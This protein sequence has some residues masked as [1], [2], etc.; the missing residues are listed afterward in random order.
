MMQDEEDDDDRSQ[1]DGYEFQDQ[2]QDQDQDENEDY[3]QGAMNIDDVNAIQDRGDSESE[4]ELTDQE[5]LVM[6]SM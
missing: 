3:H 1:T 5:Q 6:T 4:N 2:D